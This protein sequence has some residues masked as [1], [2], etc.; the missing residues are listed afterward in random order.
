MS[1][2]WTLVLLA[3]GIVIAAVI[4]SWRR[5]ADTAEL[6]TVSARWVAEQRA[7]EAHDAGR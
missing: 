5:H 1:A 4:V 3:V 2:G 7:T 6:G